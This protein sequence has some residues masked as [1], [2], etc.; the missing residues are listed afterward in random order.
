[1]A[2]LKSYNINDMPLD[3]SRSTGRSD[4]DTW[5]KY[6]IMTLLICLSGNQAF[7]LYKYSREALVIALAFLSLLLYRQKSF[8]F[9]GRFCLVLGGFT[10][11]FIS[12][13]IIFSY[14]PAI[15]IAGL[16]VRIFIAYAICCLIKDFSYF[17]INVMFW[18]SMISLC[19]F[20]PE[21]LLSILE[22]DVRPFFEPLAS[23]FSPEKE[24][25][26]LIYNFDVPNRN[27]GP[28]WEPGAFAGYLLLALIFLGLERNRY[29]ARYFWL[30][31][32]V[33]LTGLLTTFSTTGYLVLP[34]VLF[35]Y[36]RLDKRLKFISLR[37][38]AIFY[39][40]ILALEVIVFNVNKIQIERVFGKYQSEDYSAKTDGDFILK[41]LVSQTKSLK[42]GPGRYRNRFDDISSDLIYIENSP[43]FGWGI[44][45]KTRYLFHPG[46]EYESGHG[47]GLTDFIAKFGLIGLGIFLI[48]VMTSFMSLTNQHLLLSSGATLIVMG[49]LNGECF[50]GSPLFMS[51]MFLNKNGHRPAK[52]SSIGFWKS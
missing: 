49:I 38:F 37:N 21:R 16:F 3:Q 22:I 28:F 25:H 2:T 7:V 45:K 13:I 31:F 43:L 4:N 5:L 48:C 18:V 52:R 39:C 35:L 26:I 42:Q 19:F 47:E 46:T 34:F 36:L 50:L 40:S 41:K 32:F 6:A 30:R 23:L 14:F 9:S 24:F 8:R 29:P 33:I 44:H 12:H 27:A 15:T 20:I 51:L 1:M 10:L 11:I 17:Y